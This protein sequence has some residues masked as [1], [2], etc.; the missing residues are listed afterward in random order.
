MILTLWVYLVK[1]LSDVKNNDLKLGSSESDWVCARCQ[2][3]AKLFV[4]CR[5]CFLRGGPLVPVEQY[6]YVH[7]ICALFD[8]KA[9]FVN[10]KSKSAVKITFDGRLFFGECLYCN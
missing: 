5:L 4:E 1:Q 7:V 2:D 10:P 3:P 6:G 8:R 9:V